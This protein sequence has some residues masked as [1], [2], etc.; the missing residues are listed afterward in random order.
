[1][2]HLC[3]ASRCPLSLLRLLL[4]VR[5]RRNTHQLLRVIE[6]ERSSAVYHH[7]D[8][9]DEKKDRS[10]STVV[11]KTPKQGLLEFVVLLPLDFARIHGK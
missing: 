3:E 10:C 5:H 2:V 6:L 8:C 7:G 4:T 9:D 1:M 11:Q